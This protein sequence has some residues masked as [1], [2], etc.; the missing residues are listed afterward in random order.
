MSSTATTDTTA[1][2]G[3]SDASNSPAVKAEKKPKAPTKMV[4][5]SAIYL[6]MSKQKDVTRKQIVEQ[7][8]TEA[9]LS[10]AGAS[11]YYQLIKAKLG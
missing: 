4:M 5:A 2:E 3:K 9:K 1:N 7:F 6:R 8:V 10:A 11:T